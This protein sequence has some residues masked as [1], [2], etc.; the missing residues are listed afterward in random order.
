LNQITCVVF[1][2]VMDINR[3]VDAWFYRVTPVSQNGTVIGM[4]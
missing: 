3:G 2:Y 1:N 4:K